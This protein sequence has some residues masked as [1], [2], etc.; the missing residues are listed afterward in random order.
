MFCWKVASATIEYIDVV[1]RTNTTLHVSLE[2]CIDDYWKVD[3]DREL[4]GALAR[5]QPVHK[6]ERKASKWLH[7][8]RAAAHENSSTPQAR[9]FLCQ[10]SGQTCRQGRHI[11]IRK[12]GFENSAIEKPKLDNARG[13]RGIPDITLIWMTGRCNTPW[14][15]ARK[16][17]TMELPLESAML[18]K[19]VTKYGKTCC[20]NKLRMYHRSPRSTRTRIGKTQH[21]DLT[22]EK[23]VNSLS[24]ENLLHKPISKLEAMKIPDAI[25]AVDKRVGKNSKKCP[26][27]K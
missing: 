3:G 27:G 21:G 7:V 2:S 14:K 12:G 17:Y 9:L 24:H 26:H 11:E 16:T 8:V 22:A 5:F 4:S 10:K 13:L 15:K 25:A 20:V 23:G 6:I 18:C 1:K 19:T